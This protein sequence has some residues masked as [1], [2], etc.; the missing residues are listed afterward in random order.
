MN[1]QNRRINSAEFEI[2]VVDDEDIMRRTLSDILKLEGYGVQTA[3]SADEAIAR[4]EQQSKE[5]SFDLILLDLKMPVKDGLHVLRYTT[6]H[7]PQTIV[8]L[9]TAHGS[10]ESAIEALRLGAFDYLL[11]PASADQILN[12]V[13]KAVDHWAADLQRDHLLTQMEQSILALRTTQRSGIPQIASETPP[14]AEISTTRS[15]PD[16]AST[17]GGD[18][19]GFAHKN[20]HILLG[21]HIQMD[22]ARRELQTGDRRIQ[23]TPTEN[24]LLQVFLANGG[25]VFQHSEL[26]AAVYGYQAS[27]KEAGKVLRPLISRLRRK[28]KLLSDCD[29]EINGDWITCIR[30]T[31][32]VYEG[33]S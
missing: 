25:R 16:I 7:H 23:L 20:T 10:L 28:L 4:I 27:D 13:Q 29:A 12:S 1:R 22:I 11:K 15:I 33:P 14:T 5:H 26:V 31:G 3:A 17:S 32:Y 9:L 8:T 24:K 6:Q 2:L 18:K 21:Q 19:D 30:G